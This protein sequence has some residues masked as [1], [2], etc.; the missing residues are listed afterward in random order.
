MSSTKSRIKSLAGD[1]MIYG[2]FT[3]IG[4]FL[5]FLLTPLYTNYLSKQEFGDITNIFALIAIINVVF[6]FGMEPAFMRFFKSDNF[7][8]NK[9]VFTHSYFSIVGLAAT[10]IVILLVFGDFFSPMVTDLPD[11]NYIFL[12]ALLIS[13]F[14]AMVMVPYA[15][16]RMTRRA[17]RFAYTRFFLII[18]AVT[19]NIVLVVVFK[20]GAKGVLISQVITNLIGVFIFLPEIFKYFSWKIDLKLFKE[21]ML[22]GFPTVP[23]SLS[24][25]LLQVVDRPILKSLVSVNEFANY[26]LGFRLGITMMLTVAVFEYAWK[27]FYLNHREDKDA[28]ELFAKVLNYF[29]LAAGF[30]FMITVCYMDIIARMPFVG[31]RFVNPAYYEGMFIIPI[32]LFGYFFNGIYANLAAGFHIEKQ[33]KYLPISIGIAAVSK[34]ILNYTLVPVFGYQGAAWAT[35]FSYVIAAGVIYYFL[36]RIY[37][38]KYNWIAVGKVMA[39]TA[40]FYWINTLVP[41]NLTIMMKFFFKTLIMIAYCGGLVAFK[42]ISINDITRIK[43]MFSRN[44]KLS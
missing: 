13:L 28:K 25:I 37:P 20:T 22:F 6:S 42:I 39:I 19:L 18:I 31:G 26:S 17:K 14:D 10:T 23:A 41:S 1:T 5:T 9:K 38:I 3:I 12:M 33:T 15:L 43:T 8:N 24:A 34:I 36:Q 7:E 44:K 2:S 32:I 11:R 4:R 35:L 27:P 30:V 29:T 40:A 16:L 21:M